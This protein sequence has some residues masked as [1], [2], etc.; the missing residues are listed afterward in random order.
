MSQDNG[1]VSL[2]RLFLFF[3]PMGISVLLIN[4][5]HVIINGTLARSSNPEIILAGYALAMSLLVVTEKPAV[6]FRQTCSALVRDRTS[7]RAVRS[8]SFYVFGAALVFGGLVA[9]TPLGHWIFGLAYGADPIVE[10]EA[11]HAY[12]ALMF[13]SVFSGIRCLYQGVIIY[14]MRTKWLTIAMI[15]RLTGMFLLSQYF[16][17]VGVD[18]ALHGTIIF[19]FGMVIEAAISWWEASNLLKKMPE[20]AEDCDVTKPKQVTAFY[21]PLLYSSLIVV[22]LLPILNALLG[23]TDRGTL[24]VASFAVAGSLMNLILGFFTYF[25]QIALLFVKSN[26]AIVRKFTLLLGFIPPLLMLLMAFTP[27]G[28]WMF[29][30]ILG[31]KDELLTACIHAL[32]GFLPFVLVFPWLDTLNGIVMANGETKLMFGSQLANAIITAITIVLLVLLLPDWSGVL[33]S[34]AQSAGLLA[35]LI[36]LAWLFRRSHRGDK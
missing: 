12:F 33:G 28:P 14:K 10:Q 27:I 11:I 29:S 22:W 18:S 9:Y 2:R 30:H 7:F 5:S 4:L 15:F 25:H 23:T 35:E 34:L 26:P 17:H 1:P 21:N 32:R 24:A 16:L 6:L 31:V 19:V 3:I 13:L 36:F 8:V 20:K